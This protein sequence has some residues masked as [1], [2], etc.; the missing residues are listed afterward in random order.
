[1]AKI[2]KFCPS[3]YCKDLSLPN[4][5][6]VGHLVNPLPHP[7]IVHVVIECTLRLKYLTK[8]IYKI[9]P[10]RIFQAK[11][12]PVSLLVMKALNLEAKLVPK[13]V[14]DSGSKSDAKLEPVSA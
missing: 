10:N 11:L 1:M 9:L 7:L 13:L 12:Q 2:L 4:V 14:K 8:H 5:D 3:G 6:N